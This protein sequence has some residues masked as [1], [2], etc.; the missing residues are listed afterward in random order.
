MTKREALLLTRKLTAC[1][2]QQAMDEYTPDT[3]FDLLKDLSYADCETAMFKVAKRQPWVSPAEIRQQ[4]AETRRARLR[5]AELPD[6]PPELTDDPVAYLAA[7]R[8]AATA[9]GDGR[10]P[11]LAMKAVT[12]R[13]RRELG[14]S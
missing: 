5:Q 4:L 1:C 9:I 3:W 12:R 8:A 2:P 13:V 6:P 11:E 14:A 7:L 10:D